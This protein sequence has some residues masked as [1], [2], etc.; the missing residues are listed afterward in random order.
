MDKILDDLEKLEE[1][2]SQAEANYRA[3]DE[4]KPCGSCNNFL[5]PKSC[6]VVSGEISEDGTCDLYLP[7][8][9]SENA[10]LMSEG[11]YGSP[12]DLPAS[13]IDINSDLI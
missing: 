6:A 10:M 9:G 8:G 5:P 2:I 12:A 1:K 3:M 11:A 4:L 13:P 7:S